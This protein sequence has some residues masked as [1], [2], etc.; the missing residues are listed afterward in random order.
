MLTVDAEVAN[1]TLGSVGLAFATGNVAVT[2]P[3]GG[4]VSFG[5]AD[6]MP[7]VVN[8]NNLLQLL[9]NHTHD[10]VVA[11]AKTTAVPDPSL[12]AIVG[13]WATALKAK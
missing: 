13:S 4:A 5:G 10:V 11:G 12:A 1:L 7:A 8:S 9:A 2:V 3:A 6:G